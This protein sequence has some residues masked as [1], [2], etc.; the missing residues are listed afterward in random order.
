MGIHSRE[1]GYSSYYV[2]YSDSEKG[3]WRSGIKANESHDPWDDG[4]ARLASL[5]GKG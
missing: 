5:P 3:T 2:G 4:E 1:E